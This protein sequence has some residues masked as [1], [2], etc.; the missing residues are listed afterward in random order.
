MES[1]EINNVKEV[2]DIV[3]WGSSHLD[4]LNKYIRN[5]ERIFP[6]G[7][8]FR[9]QENADWPLVPSVFRSKK[10]IDLTPPVLA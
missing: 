5:Y 4:D 8:W 1:Y 10:C 2:F 3:R 9:G 6:Y 7:T